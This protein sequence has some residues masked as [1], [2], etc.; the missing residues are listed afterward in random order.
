MSSGTVA[1]SPITVSVSK[2]V[3]LTMMK[4]QLLLSKKTRF[5]SWFVNLGYGLLVRLRP[6]HACVE[7][8]V[9]T[10]PVPKQMPTA[11]SLVSALIVT[12]FPFTT[13][14]NSKMEHHSFSKL[15]M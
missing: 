10:T 1:V 13:K 5:S 3:N 8:M 15:A 14:S 9:F 12:H 11:P 6:E 4:E 7:V 2:V